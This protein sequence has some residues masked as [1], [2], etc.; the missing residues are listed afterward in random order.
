M[1]TED[2]FR[3]LI[4]KDNAYDSTITLRF[5]VTE[6]MAQFS[7]KAPGRAE[8]PLTVHHEEVGIDPDLLRAAR[9]VYTLNQQRQS[10]ALSRITSELCGRVPSDQ[11]TELKTIIEFGFRYLVIPDDV[12]SAAP[13]PVQVQIAAVQVTPSVAPAAVPRSAGAAAAVRVGEPARAESALADRPVPME[14]GLAAAA[15]EGLSR[16]A[17]LQHLRVQLTA[18]EGLH[19]RLE[20]M[21]RKLASSRSRERDLLAV[22]TRWQERDSDS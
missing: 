13:A 2:P 8:P 4:R 11:W 1:A 6:G 18:V 3:V 22:L 16:E 15:L 5:N 17:A 19:Q 14:P 9:F 21:E 10:F 7:L 12:L 20:M